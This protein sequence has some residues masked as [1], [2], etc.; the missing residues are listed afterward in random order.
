MTLRPIWL[1]DVNITALKV[2][3]QVLLPPFLVF[4]L[5]S[6]VFVLLLVL[7]NCVLLLRLVLVSF[8]V[9]LSL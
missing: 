7:V 2:V 9:S 3:G 6:L 1:R 4:V 5:I 8:F